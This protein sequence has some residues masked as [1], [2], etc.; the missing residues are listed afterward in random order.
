MFKFNSCN[1]SLLLLPLLGRRSS[2]VGFSRASFLFSS[3]F[4]LIVGPSDYRQTVNNSSQPAPFHQI[5][6]FKRKKAG[7]N[8]ANAILSVRLLSLCR[9]A[10]E[11]NV[12][13]V[14]ISLIGG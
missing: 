5:R 3:S 10:R 8:A 4:S 14:R 6:C 12:C 13:W 1:C 2:P 11:R 7:S 9:G